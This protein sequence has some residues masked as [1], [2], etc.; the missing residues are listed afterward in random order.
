MEV[1]QLESHGE[2]AE[3]VRRTCAFLATE[4][5]AA[6]KMW[7]LEM[8][9]TAHPVHQ[10]LARVEKEQVAVVVQQGQVAS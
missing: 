10:P 8:H 6:R 3:V 5:M 4:R 7:S 1:G 9:H 2:A